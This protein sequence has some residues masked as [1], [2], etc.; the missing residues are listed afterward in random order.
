MGVERR[1]DKRFCPKK[2]TYVALR[3]EFT[4]LGK[5]I[6]ISVGGLCFNYMAKSEQDGDASEIV[7]DV[8]LFISGNGYYLPSLSCKKVHEVVA[9]PA[10]AAAG[11]MHNRRCGV[12]FL[13]LTDEQQGQIDQYL[14][15]HAE[16]LEG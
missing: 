7:L 4:K 14:E 15:T 8:D 2:L 6:D 1:I 16:G 3:P 10:R 12:Q 11:G 9:D 5:V 13:D